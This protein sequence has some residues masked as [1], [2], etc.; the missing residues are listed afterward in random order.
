MVSLLHGVSVISWMRIT[1]SMVG[2]SLYNYLFMPSS[3]NNRL[4][5]SMLKGNMARCN[6]SYEFNWDHVNQILLHDGTMLNW[7]EMSNN[8]VQVTIGP[9]IQGLTIDG[10]PLKCLCVDED[11]HRKSKQ[12]LAVIP[13]LFSDVCDIRQFQRPLDLT[14]ESHSGGEDIIEHAFSCAFDESVWK[15][16]ILQDFQDLR[17]SFLQ[18]RALSFDNAAG[19][20]FMNRLMQFLCWIN[21][22]LSKYCNV[23]TNPS[24]EE[25][26]GCTNLGYSW[27]KYV[28]DRTPSHTP[29]S[30]SSSASSTP[31]PEE[32]VHVGGFRDEHH[33]RYSDS[34]FWDLVKEIYK[35]IIEVKSTDRQPAEHQTTEQMVGLFRACQQ[36]MLGVIVKPNNI[37]IKILEKSS[38]HDFQM[39]SLPE[40]PLDNAGTLMLVSKL[41]IAFIFFVDC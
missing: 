10:V 8:M 20:V 33:S 16:I 39:H 15:N 26:P 23:G 29:I 24:G 3:E 27:L 34:V 19:K 25:Q 9:E 18:A 12:L 40:M 14:E 6:G 38:P 11:I 36:Y 5:S 17:L 31:I 32:E 2:C 28:S 13:H 4:W 22:D 30:T 35:V 21:R 41:I 7:T 37:A 1:I